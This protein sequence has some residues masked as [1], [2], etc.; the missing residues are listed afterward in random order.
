VAAATAGDPDLE[1]LVLDILRS[2][3]LEGTF[4]DSVVP[5]E[6]ARQVAE[7]LIDSAPRG[8]EADRES[9]RAAGYELSEPLGSGGFGTVWLARRLEPV[10]REVALEVLELVWVPEALA[11]RFRKF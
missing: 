10:R 8:R 3:T 6:Q 2:A 9:D 1:K 4:L 5:G 7:A 11:Y